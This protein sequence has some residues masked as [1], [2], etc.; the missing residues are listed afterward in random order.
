MSGS[1]L[2][3]ATTGAQIEA[4]LNVFHGNDGDIV[5]ILSHTRVRAAAQPH[6]PGAEGL[7]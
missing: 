3:R 4:S 2:C 7:S 5:D 1:P 6:S